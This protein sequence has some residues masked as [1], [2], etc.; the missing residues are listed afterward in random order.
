MILTLPIP[1]A[2]LNAHNKGHWRSKSAAV[3]SCRRLACAETLALRPPSLD[4]SVLS[5]D[6]YWPDLLNRDTFNAVQ[7]CKPY[8]DGIVDA[9]VIPDDNWRVMS[10]GH[11]RSHLD[12][13]NPRV[14]LT[15]EPESPEGRESE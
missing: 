2:T 6:L 8:I 12:R 13:E 14:V 3:K 4:R 11:V 7:S 9:G 1:P 15:I 10:I 5:I